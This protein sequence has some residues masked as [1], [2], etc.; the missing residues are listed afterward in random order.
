MFRSYLKGIKLG[1]VG[2]LKLPIGTYGLLLTAELMYIAVQCITVYQLSQIDTAGGSC[3][4]ALMWS[5]KFRELPRALQLAQSDAGVVTKSLARLLPS[6]ISWAEM[7]DE[8]V[9]GAHQIKAVISRVQTGMEEV[10]G[11]RSALRYASGHGGDANDATAILDRLS[12]ITN[13]TQRN[14]TMLL[15]KLGDLRESIEQDHFYLRFEQKHRMRD[16]HMYI[17]NRYNWCGLAG[18][19]W[20]SEATLRGSQAELVEAQQTLNHTYN[21]AMDAYT[22]TATI[23]R[24]RRGP[25]TPGIFSGNMGTV[26]GVLCLAAGGGATYLVCSFPASFL[27]G[28][29]C[30]YEVFQRHLDSCQITNG[31]LA[32]GTYI[33]SL[34]NFSKVAVHT[35]DYRHVASVLRRAKIDSAVLIGALQFGGEQRDYIKTTE[36]KIKQYDAE[37]SKSANAWAALSSRLRSGTNHLVAVNSD[38]DRYFDDV[39]GLSAYIWHLFSS[40]DDLAT[41][42]LKAELMSCIKAILGILNHV[43][44]KADTVEVHIHSLNILAHQITQAA[45]HAAAI[46]YQ[47]G[48]QRTADGLVYVPG[49]CGWFNLCGLIKPTPISSHGVTTLIHTLKGQHQYHKEA[50]NAI[51][52]IKIIIKDT[53]HSLEGVANTTQSPLSI[54]GEDRRAA[55]MF[56]LKFARKELRGTLFELN[57][58][59]AK[60]KG[61]HEEPSIPNQLTPAF[62]FPIMNLPKR[63]RSRLYEEREPRSVMDFNWAEEWLP[64]CQPRPGLGMDAIIRAG[65]DFT[66][67]GKQAHEFR[68]LPRAL[69][70]TWENFEV[71]YKSL[72][73][74]LGKREDFLATTMLAT[75]YRSGLSH[76]IDSW[77]SIYEDVIKTTE[78]VEGVMVDLQPF[79]D[80][81]SGHTPIVDYASGHP[82]GSYFMLKSRVDL[83]VLNMDEVFSRSLFTT[84]GTHSKL[85]EL[86]AIVEDLSLNARKSY[87]ALQRDEKEAWTNGYQNQQ[88]TCGLSNLCGVIGG[89]GRMSAV[90]L[91][92]LLEQLQDLLKTLD[93][94]HK[95]AYSALRAFNNMTNIAEDTHGTLM[96]AWDDGKRFEWNSAKKDILINANRWKLRLQQLVNQL[97]TQRGQLHHLNLNRDTEPMKFILR[98]QNV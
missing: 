39:I 33:G 59:K 62:H 40:T 76:S 94:V 51:D 95:L 17:C 52:G 23:Q 93:D 36:N 60:F 48:V 29:M 87:E 7:S 38:M 97:S 41:I 96:R 89:P 14:F 25:D 42:R 49:S 91:G 66:L 10:S 44:E 74:A 63:N 53:R 9:D 12:L 84:P 64:P 22:A 30:A 28:Y 88:A 55:I 2:I 56:A 26:K 47:D 67:V 4:V 43:W 70:L 85:K 73:K 24:Y 3:A 69:A 8:I 21:L 72:E 18:P 75:K 32:V 83:W 45:E 82:D 27:V 35:E 78:W 92:N 20:V 50:E 15:Q 71:V 34:A 80:D 81:V 46:M 1:P 11:L 86:L 68:E 61:F 19:N 98:H 65:T 58:M 16:G 6:I 37:L 13:Q 77:T 57:R 5:N 90:D 54:D 79:I 31:T